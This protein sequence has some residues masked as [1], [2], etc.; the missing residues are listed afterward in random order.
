MLYNINAK[1]KLS[2]YRSIMKVYRVNGSN[3]TQILDLGSRKM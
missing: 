3:A 2:P 1:L